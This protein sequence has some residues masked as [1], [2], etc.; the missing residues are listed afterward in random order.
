MD[1]CYYTYSFIT[2]T[3]SIN[4]GIRPWQWQKR[5]RRRDLPE[6]LGLW[7]SLIYCLSSLMAHLKIQLISTR[8]ESPGKEESALQTKSLYAHSI[9]FIIQRT[10]YYC[11]NIPLPPLSDVTPFWSGSIHYTRQDPH[12]RWCLNLSDSPWQFNSILFLLLHVTTTPL[13]QYPFTS[14]LSCHGYL[15]WW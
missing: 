5:V 13:S 15:A 7:K 4:C 6:I 1:D 12:G 10:V 8:F 2:N 11:D 14:T 9:S 3:H